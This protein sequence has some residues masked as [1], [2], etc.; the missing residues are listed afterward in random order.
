MRREDNSRQGV[1]VRASARG[2]GGS[3]F[4]AQLSG[5]LFRAFMV[6]VLV[7]LPALML[8]SV[9]GDTAQIV[10]LLAL[11]AG[12]VVLAEYS[13][14]CPGLIEF[15]DARPY[16]RLRFIL[17]FFLVLLLSIL[18]RVEVMPTHFG[19][20]LEGFAGALG[21]GMDFAYS[22][23]WLL[24]Q[25]LPPGLPQSHLAGVQAG[26]ALALVMAALSIAAFL[27]AIIVGYWPRRRDAFNVWVN[28]PTFDP[29][30]GQDV[31]QRLER[32]ALV[33]VALGILLPFVLPVLLRLSTLLVQPVTLE[34]PLAFVWGIAL[35]A[36]V[37][38]NLIMRG[39]AM[40]QV[41]RLIREKRRQVVALEE[42]I[43]Q[44]VESS[45]YS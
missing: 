5:A 3:S 14:A 32:D 9:A 18:A 34:S 26:A 39:I 8:P 30:A 31:V 40:Q 22:P 4:M 37:P 19:Q 20:W 15:R 29:T 6:A 33:N 10:T 27:L 41:A 2:R 13:A 36:F 45:V 17:L 11:V 44:R 21:Q 38:V 12:A 24:L 42:S 43:P 1:P 23:A 16:N 28:L 25:A 35:W 7:A